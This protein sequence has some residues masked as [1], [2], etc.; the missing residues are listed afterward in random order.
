[1]T[2]LAIAIGGALGSLARAE[3]GWWQ[4]RRGDP[5]RGTLLVNL[6]G[7]AVL[8]VAT[9]GT[10]SLLAPG[11]ARE[12][13]V[14]GFLG[15]FTTFSTWMAQASEEP[16]PAAIGRATATLAA[17]ALV[18]LAARWLTVTAMG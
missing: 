7:A 12:L 17:G 10:R 18:V 11:A 4:T 3:V 9:S 14:I 2:W 6:L 8:G 1:V 5:R 16:V 13:L 15:G